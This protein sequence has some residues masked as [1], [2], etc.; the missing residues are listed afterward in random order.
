M[1]PSV[2]PCQSISVPERLVTRMRA[3]SSVRRVPTRVGLL[4]L[5]SSSA[6]LE[7]WIGPSRSITPTGAFGRAGFGRW[8]RLTM[9]MPSTKT[10]SLDRSTRRILPV[11]PLSLPEITMTWS[12]ARSF[13]SEHLRGERDDLHEP[14][15][16]Q[17]AGHGPEDARPARVVLGVDDHGRVLVEGDVGAVLAPE[18]LL[19]AHDDGLDDLAL[20]DRPLRGGLLDRRGDDVAHARVAAAR[21]ALD[22]DAEDLAGAGVVGNLEARLVLDH[23]ARSSTSV[24]RQRFVRLIGRHSTIRTV[25]PSP[26]VFASSWAYSFCVERMILW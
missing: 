12:S 15:V 25:S 17:L 8:W 1:R 9:L 7:T 26:A 2:V 18:L 6:T 14:A 5:G 21:A 3:P 13:I 23:F 10:R 24:S 19:R 4:S 11:L 20:L 16:A 22:A